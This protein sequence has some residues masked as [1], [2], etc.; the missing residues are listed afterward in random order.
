MAW[1]EK[2]NGTYRVCFRDGNQI[3]RIAAYTDKSASKAKLVEL[4]RAIARGENGL[5]DPFAAHKG[6]SITDHL[7]DWITELRQ[8]GRGS[9]YIGLCESRI[10]RLVADCGWKTLKSISADAFIAWRDKPGKLGPRTINHYLT[11]LRSFCVWCVR[12]KRMATNPVSDIEPVIESGDV[13]RARRALHEGEVMR[14]LAALPAEYKLLYRTLLGTGLRAGEAAALQWGD[15]RL[16]SPSPFIQLR[17]ETTKSKRADVIPLRIELAEGLRGTRGD[18]G[19]ADRV[20]RRVPRAKEHRRWLESAGIAYVDDT[21]RRADVHSLRHTYGTML[22]KVGVAPREAM[23]LMRHTDMRL[24]MKVYTDPRIFNL[25]AAVEKLPS[26]MLDEKQ[27]QAATGTNGTDGGEQGANRVANALT[28]GH[29]LALTGTIGEGRK[30]A[31]LPGKQADLPSSA[32]TGKRAGEGGR[33]LDIHVG[34]VT[35][36]H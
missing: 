12:R 26:L 6:R 7:A 5:V 23:S 14:L 16:D 8:A 36:Y 11:T 20:F 25:A 4:E 18:A 33:T 24:T 27:A 10:K 2:R 32:L 30:D 9:I 13:R 3:K 29:L 31:N 22:S 19:D 1:L 35:L 21:G 17:A 34:N 28:K 15:V